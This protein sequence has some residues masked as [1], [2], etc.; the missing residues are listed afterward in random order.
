MSSAVLSFDPRYSGGGYSPSR[1]VSQPAMHVTALFKR[2]LDDAWRTVSGRPAGLE[3]LPELDESYRDAQAQAQ[4]D[5]EQISPSP[6]AMQEANDLL[7]SL[8]PWCP[9]PS[10]AIEH[11][12]AIALEWDLGPNRWLLLALKGTGS[13]ELSAILGLGNEFHWKTTFA[14]GLGKREHELLREL[15]DLKA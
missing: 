3:A 10:P 4:H 6:A 13:I 1:G 5:E 8:P 12:G 2:R 7:I 11:S 14:G 15:V 9:T